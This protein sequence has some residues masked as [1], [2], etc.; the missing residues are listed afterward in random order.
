MITLPTMEQQ[1]YAHFIDAL[2]L[3]DFVDD[4]E[5]ER[6][7]ISLEGEISC[8]AKDRETGRTL[9]KIVR[10]YKEVPYAPV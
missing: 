4:T 7:A 1:I 9:A 10:S 2:A 6:I 8:S 5:L 3:L